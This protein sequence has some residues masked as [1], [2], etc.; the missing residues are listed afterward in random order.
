IEIRFVKNAYRN[1]PPPKESAENMDTGA[2]TASAQPVNRRFAFVTLVTSDGYVDGALVLLHSLRRTL[3]PYSIVCL[4]TPSTLSEH[5][6]GRLRQHFDGVIETD[7][8]LSLDDH[9]L[10]LLGRP[11]LRSTLTKIQL[12][13]PALFGAWDALCYLDADTLVRQS[14]DDIFLR[15]HSWRDDCPQW[16]EGGLVAASPDTGW[17][18]CFNSG[19]LL[20]APGYGCYQD[21]VRRTCSLSPSFDGADQGLLNEQF[22]DWS[23]APSYRRLPF[24][25]NSTANI[26][27]TYRPALERFGHEVRVVHFIGVSK[28]WNWERTPGGQLVADSTT[29]ERWRQLISLW[30]N[31]HD[32]HVSGWKFWRGPFFKSAAFGAGYHHITEPPISEPVPDFQ[33]SQHRSSGDN[34]SFSVP[35]VDSHGD[36]HQHQKQLVHEV[37]DWDKDW[38]WADDR[39]H[40]LDYAYLRSH[41]VPSTSGHHSPQ[42]TQHYHGDGAGNPHHH[43]HHHHPQQH[44]DHHD[45]HY[46]HD[47]QHEQQQQQQQQQ[48]HHDHHHHH[49]H[50]DTDFANDHSHWTPDHHEQHSEHSEHKGHSGLPH[51][52]GGPGNH[53]HDSA[54]W[55][56]NGH[57]HSEHVHD[58]P[59]NDHYVNSGDSSRHDHHNAQA[60]SRSTPP[61]PAWM[62]SQ[63]PWEDAARE[64]WMHHDEYK[65]HVY[66]QSYIERRLPDYSQDY[67]H[68]DS[69]N[70]KDHYH[71]TG[72]YQ[73]SNQHHDH[74]HGD[75]GHHGWG[76]PVW[77]DRSGHSHQYMPMPLPHNQRLYEASQVVLQPRD[78]GHGGYGNDNDNQH[79]Q[80]DYHN[81]SDSDQHFDQPHSV[82]SSRSN[83][84]SSPLYYPQPKSPMVVNPV[85]LWESSEEQ[86]RRRAWVQHVRAP[87]G[88]QQRHAD[89]A[90]AAVPMFDSPSGTVPD[91]QAA[92]SSIDHIDSSQLPPETPWK[93]SHV[94]QR[95][96]NDDAAPANA[97]PAPRAAM[98]FKEG[99]ANDGNARDAAGQLLQR[100]NEAVIL[101][102][103]KPRFGEVGSDHISHSAPK[104]ERGTDA[105][106]LE[107]T[108]SCEAEDSKG[109]RTVYRFTLSSTLDVGG[110]QGASTSTAAVPGQQA[111]AQAQAQAQMQPQPYLQKRAVPAKI[112]ATAGAPAHSMEPMAYAAKQP[113]QP[114][115]PRGTL[116]PVEHDD[117]DDDYT[118]VVDLRQPLNYQEPAMSRRSSFVQFP[119]AASSRSAQMTARSGPDT[120]DQFAVA[121]TRYW[122]LQRQLIDLEMSQRRQDNAKQSDK[123]SMP[124]VFGHTA[125]TG[126]WEVQGVDPA[127]L[128]SPPTPTHKPS[129]FGIES[130]GG[131]RLVRRS[132]AFSIADPAVALEDQVP[133]EAT[134]AYR[135]ED[136][137]VLKEAQSRGRSRSSPK[138]AGLMVSEQ[139]KHQEVVSRPDPSFGNGLQLTGTDAQLPSQ[140]K[141]SRSH[142]ALLRIATENSAQAASSLHSTG[143]PTKVQEVDLQKHV[144]VLPVSPVQAADD[145]NSV[146]D[147]DFK[148]AIGRKPTPFPRSMLTKRVNDLG[149]PDDSENAGSTEDQPETSGTDERPT[150]NIQSGGL[151]KR[152]NVPHS[153]DIEPAAGGFEPSQFDA[154]S[155]SSGTPMTPGRQK[156][157][158]L[159]NWGDEDSGNIAP[160]DDDMSINAQW[161][162]IVNGAPPPRASVVAPIKALPAKS[163]E[164]TTSE[165]VKNTMEKLAEKTIEAASDNAD[166]ADGADGADADSKI[167]NADIHIDT[168]AEGLRILTIPATG[169]DSQATANINAASSEKHP[170][171]QHNEEKNTDKPAATVP[172]ATGTR[173]PPRKLHSTKSFL[174]LTS[175]VYDTMSDSEMDPGELEL[176]ERFWA[177]AMKP[178]KSGTS[179]PY[180]PGRRKSIVEMSSAISPRDLEE[181]MQWQGE[182]GSA[183]S[184]H[185]D[186]DSDA[187][188]EP[189]SQETGRSVDN[190]IT[191]PAS[192]EREAGTATNVSAEGFGS[193]SADDAIIEDAGNDLSLVDDA[194]DEYDDDNYDHGYDNEG[195][196]ES[197]DSDYDDD[198]DD[199][200]ELEMQFSSENKHKYT[201]PTKIANPAQLLHVS[202]VD[203]DRNNNDN[204]QLEAGDSGAGYVEASSKV[205]Q[206]TQ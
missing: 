204:E 109:E 51:N 100:W 195:E 10:E 26:Y 200:D 17:P 153:L 176:Q 135:D 48:Q 57:H 150:V 2:D 175:K 18:D 81:H 167:D 88:E 1:D 68:S 61:P 202:T 73:H 113:L 151:G 49:H 21:L 37:P 114:L 174:N 12:W 94:R 181:W 38:S 64:G 13:D 59:H 41:N 7:V 46:H 157:R 34:S 69:G 30:W 75:G 155:M 71:D 83:T 198:S 149:G 104:L 162:R 84:G 179:T 143:A 76:H 206:P 132:S 6:I 161:L 116:D 54:N 14:I 194:D 127:D 172:V 74:D 8:R 43:H 165:I 97:S 119:P 159:I 79:S 24:L 129:S 23:T 192:K 28:P 137:S 138:L 63:R 125:T 90:I 3:T 139:K 106:R 110:A 98:Q 170:A 33:G 31:I 166:N 141:R 186:P 55:N 190:M 39:V 36:Q 173:A 107:T 103:I 191:P 92:P 203:V 184:R 115:Q 199:S 20:L 178:L 32:E 47:H 140:P 9:G 93:I 78:S 52:D 134:S 118:R 182:S 180:T 95:Q 65:P 80:H 169:D 77:H 193:E 50:R 72:S 121:D 160:P 128:A 189:G 99:V 96:V 136:S 124:N 86:A 131:R 187:V 117:E 163:K 188:E 130:Q 154:L 152:K 15:Y 171:E 45:H 27:Y 44:H 105:I 25:Y 42:P 126:G 102:N 142:S 89:A 60:A 58:P 111:Q 22:S 133:T 156:I 67:H 185:P 158:P 145:G 168:S 112:P 148:S 85:A 146:E 53:A 108:V 164:Q 56:N 123:V 91:Q 147:K 197:A 66:D 62:Q 201:A 16:Q 177:R 35:T 11:D 87:L 120:R 144:S 40:P 205:A 70:A 4:A 19:V 122:K 183:V 5:S 29:P 82:R 101:R 196:E